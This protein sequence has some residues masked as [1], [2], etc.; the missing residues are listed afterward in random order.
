[1]YLIYTTVCLCSLI[2]SLTITPLIK[3]TAI[4]FK[5]MDIPSPRKIHHQPM[6]RL[7]GIATFIATSIAIFIG[8]WLIDRY[9]YPGESLNIILPF[10]LGGLFLFLI[11]LMDDLI[12]LSASNRLWAQ[13]MIAVSLWISGLRIETLFAW[14][15]MNRGTEDGFEKQK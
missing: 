4:K 11:G 2:I 3:L 8:V 6:V 14:K 7:G 5:K 1:M 15:M 9:T 10:F 13:I 12:N